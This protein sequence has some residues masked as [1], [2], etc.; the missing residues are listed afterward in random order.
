[1]QDSTPVSG[2]PFRSAFC[3]ILCLL[4]PGIA[5]AE[6][7]TVSGQ[8]NIFAAGSS[9]LADGLAPSEYDFSTAYPSVLSFS[10]VTGAVSGDLGA[11]PFNGPDGG[12]AG[13]LN[14]FV[15]G[16]AGISGISGNISTFYL[17][18]V[19]L[20]PNQ[21]LAP[22]PPSLDFGYGAVGIGFTTL[23]PEI[24]QVFFIGDGLTGTGTGATQQFFV[25]DGATR[26]FLGIADNSGVYGAPAGFYSDNA[27]QYQ[28]IFTIAVVPVPDTT[29]P[30]LTLPAS[31]AV[32]ATSPQGATVSYTVTATDNSGVTPTVSCI[33]RSGL[34]FAIGPTTV[35]C[36]ATDAANNS[37]T[38]S[39]TVT[40]NGA[41]AQLLKLIAMVGI[42]SNPFG[43][44]NSLD[45]KLQNAMKEGRS[46]C[47][48]LGAFI[49]E[50]QALS[51]KKLH[52]EQANMLIESA[53]QI[54]AVLGC[55]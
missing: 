10:S 46:A 1:M 31:F 28:T 29:P 14:H 40:V 52:V 26:L 16:N 36:T 41:E 22:A 15:S 47:N 18:A 50:A 51:G 53:N 3:A 54:R 49:N 34:T 48:S 55:Q 32:D 6:T 24:G 13:V 35:N 23:S 11:F 4:G 5:W 27:G 19:F 12:T 37:S 25:P 33:P 20:G 8:A 30:V 2:K 7:L 42:V 21:P 43:I 44:T 38:G 9:L 17:A 45:K 39:F